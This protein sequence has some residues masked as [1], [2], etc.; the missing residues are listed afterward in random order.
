MT[1]V[2]WMILFLLVMGLILWNLVLTLQIY[3]LKNRFSHQESPSPEATPLKKGCINRLR[4]SALNMNPL[5][6]DPY[7]PPIKQRIEPMTVKRDGNG[8][9]VEEC[10]IASGRLRF[11]WV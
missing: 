4:L 5:L 2:G 11:F 7:R 6:N 10:S 1:M 9:S 3:T 8:L